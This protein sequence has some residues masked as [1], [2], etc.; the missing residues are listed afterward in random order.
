MSSLERECKLEGCTN[1]VKGSQN[2]CCQ[3]HAYKITC[4]VYDPSHPDGYYFTLTDEQVKDRLE[5]RKISQQKT[6]ERKRSLHQVR[7]E[8]EH[9]LSA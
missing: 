2:Y 7:G 1:P 4:T 6:Y 3:L 9:P 5:R 8:S